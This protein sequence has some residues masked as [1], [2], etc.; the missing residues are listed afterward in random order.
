MK[1]F[2][3]HNRY[4]WPTG[5]FGSKNILQFPPTGFITFATCVTRWV[6]AWAFHSVKSIDNRLCNRLHIRFTRTTWT[7]VC[8]ICPTLTVTQETMFDVQ[9]GPGMDENVSNAIVH[10]LNALR[11]PEPRSPRDICQWEHVSKTYAKHKT[12]SMQDNLISNKI[13]SELRRE[14]FNSIQFNS[15]VYSD[16]ED[17][18]IQRKMNMLM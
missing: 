14:S 16:S 12:R 7:A 3:T 6:E 11:L 2:S 9:L 8:P 5:F 1:H 15:I 17:P 4:S 10:G 13:I 18:S